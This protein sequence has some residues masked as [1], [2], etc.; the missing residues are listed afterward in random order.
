MSATANTI[1]LTKGSVGPVVRSAAAEPTTDN[2]QTTGVGLGD[3]WFDTVNGSVLICTDKTTS[4]AVWKVIAGALE[5]AATG[6][7]ERVISETKLGNGSVRRTAYL[8][9]AVVTSA[10][11]FVALTTSIPANSKVIAASLNFDTAIVLSTATKVGFGF[12]G[13]PSGLVL[14][15]TV[16]TKNTKNDTVAPTTTSFA[17]ATALRVSAVDNSG[18]AAGTITSGTVRARVIYEYI[19]SIGDAP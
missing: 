6:V 18:A 9:E 5:P 7:T 12:S 3:L 14:S 15:S 13:T 11:A 8:E 17:T 1:A 16:V 10:S 19:T 2:D 4:A